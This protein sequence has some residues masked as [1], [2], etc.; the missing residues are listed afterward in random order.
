MTC[1][2]LISGTLPDFRWLRWNT[3]PSTFPDSLDF[4]NGSYTLVNPRQYQTVHVGGKYGVKVNIWNVQP[5]D[6]GLYTCYVSNHLG[7]DYMSAF[8]TEE[9]DRRKES[10]GKLRTKR[11][12]RC[13]VEM[14]YVKSFNYIMGCE[15]TIQHRKI[16]PG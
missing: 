14:V 7:S 16:A 1:I 5:K 3:I 9:K 6:L 11:T 4:E 15:E 12:L 8:L 2:V 13:F 10:E